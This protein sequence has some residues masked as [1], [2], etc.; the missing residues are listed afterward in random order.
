MPSLEFL[1]YNINIRVRE[2]MILNLMNIEDTDH[3]LDL[4]GGLGY[5]SFIFRQNNKK[6]KIFLL[7]VDKESLKFAKR[8]MSKECFYIVG[9]ATRLPFKN[10]SLSK[11]LVTEVLE[12]IIDDE[13]AIH[14]IF[15]SLKRFGECVIS[16]PCYDYPLFLKTLIHVGT[17][18]Q[19]HYREGYKTDE[20]V[21]MLTRSGLKPNEIKYC[22]GIISALI[23]KL[24]EIF[25]ILRMGKYK[26]QS[27]LFY[28]KKSSFFEIYKK[29]F[30]FVDG[31][32]KFE[33]C[34][35]QIP[36]VKGQIV[37]VRCVK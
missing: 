9:D 23:F 17:G 1:K 14:E 21:E 35:S 8:C 37:I 31:I 6:P 2:D 33:N 16:A 30:Y 5:F 22:N 10:N 25:Y 28:L 34:L 12:H 13:I 11:I 24:M 4:G 18:P 26:T 29:L 7:D 3:I 32:S 20:L 15:R 36:F 27:K 19:M